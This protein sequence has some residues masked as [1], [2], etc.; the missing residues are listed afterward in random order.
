[1]KMR[2]TKTSSNP[3]SPAHALYLRN[4]K[5]EKLFIS[6]VRGAVL[7]ILFALWEFSARVG[8][9]DPFIFSSPSRSLSVIY[10]MI[11]DGSIWP[12]IGITVTETLIGFVAGTALGISIA[13][14]L[15]FFPKAREISDPYLVVLNGLPKIAL[16]PVI[17]VWVGSGIQSIVAVT[18][19]VSVV[20]T[21]IG[22]LNGFT[23]TDKEKILLMKTFGANKILTFTKVVFPAALPTTV[24]VLKINVGMTWVGVIVGEFLTSKAGIGYL[25][26]YGGQVFRMDLVMAGVLILCLLAGIMY[27]GVSACEKTIKRKMAE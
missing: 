14:L 16:G 26:V 15:W 7:V 13:I 2:K 1:M 8:L 17:I 3:I 25:I 12:H 27:Y 10:R 22:V 4:L 21:V 18:L 6:I 23:E 20:V 19:F 11:A 5:K 24:S 9:I